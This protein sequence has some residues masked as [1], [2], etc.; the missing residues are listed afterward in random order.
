MESYMQE[1]LLLTL[2]SALSPISTHCTDQE[3]GVSL[4]SNDFDFSSDEFNN[5]KEVTGTGSI[6]G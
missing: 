4:A 3:E 6:F 2:I 1:L 5:N